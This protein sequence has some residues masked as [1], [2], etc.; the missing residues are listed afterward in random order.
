MSRC[1]AAPR[2]SA[3]LAPSTV[4]F[5][6]AVDAA[7]DP[8]SCTIALGQVPGVY[9]PGDSVFYEC[10]SDRARPLSIFVPWLA[11]HSPFGRFS[12]AM[13]DLDWP[14]QLKTCQNRITELK[15]KLRLKD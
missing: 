9:T 8:K 7:A 5:T 14:A 6:Y 4:T 11:D 2:K 15:K 13:I 1:D 12:M 10:A 3:P